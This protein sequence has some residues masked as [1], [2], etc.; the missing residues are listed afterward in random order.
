MALSSTLKHVAML[1]LLAMFVAC[2]SQ[3]ENLNTKSNIDSRT[4]YLSVIYD[5]MLSLI[6]VGN[7]LV[8]MNGDRREFSAEI[9]NINNFNE[10]L[11]YKFKYYDKQGFEIKLKNNPWKIINIA[12]YES[13]SLQSVS[14]SNRVIYAKLFVEKKN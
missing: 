9:I 2:A 14:P 8:R 6:K 10:Q 1:C 11:Q 13:M 7:E 4:P 5:P 12:P 3:K